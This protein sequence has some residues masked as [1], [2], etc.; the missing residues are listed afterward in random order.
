MAWSFADIGDQ[1]G[2]VAL[3]TG[4][5]S[6]IGEPTARELGRAGARVVIACRNEQKA[7]AALTRLRQA[8][9][10]G[11]F[12][13]VP[14]DLADLGSVQAC[15]AQLGA[16]EERLDLLVNNAGVMIPPYSKTKDGFELQFGTN[17]LGHFALTA[18]LLDQVVA[19]P[20]SRI[21]TVASMAH[22]FG[23]IKFSDL[24]RERFYSRWLTYAQSKVANLFFSYE[25]QRRL[26]ATGHQTLAVAAHPGWARTNL[27]KYAWMA[28]VFGPV[29][30]QGPEGGAAP[31]LRAATDVD[32][33]PGSYYGP[34][35]LE[36]RGPAVKVSSTR[37]SRRVDVAARLWQGSQ[38]LTGLSLLD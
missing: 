29:L 11:D 32:A 16:T 18:H 26:H 31:T 14:L 5:N 9:P 33:A 25:L 22:R 28:R 7:Q 12:D 3:V 10:D 38:Q 21:V 2:R 15:A 37:Y 27:M 6:G 35:W 23:R 24:N 30:A 34:R 19:T 17:H 13:F 1:S 4:A 36:I 20:N 8:V